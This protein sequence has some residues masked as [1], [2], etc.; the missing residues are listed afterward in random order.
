MS[1]R[2]ALLLS[3]VAIGLA[4][5]GGSEKQNGPP[6]ISYGEETCTRC[7]M[8]ITD[9]RHAAALTGGSAGQL[10]FDDIGELVATVQETELD[11]RKVW[12]HSYDTKVWLDGISAYYVVDPS[13]YTPMGTGVVAFATNE[14]AATFLGS[15]NGTVLTWSELLGSWTIE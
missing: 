9:E 2:R 8:L 14:A 13:R 5:C 11:L 4:G 10:L 1:T 6:K 3:A 7:G 15:A 12:V